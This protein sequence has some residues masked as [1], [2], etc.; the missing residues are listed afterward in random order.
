MKVCM[1]IP[2]NN[3]VKTVYQSKVYTEKRK[4]KWEKLKLQNVVESKD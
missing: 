1:A 2:E 3:A 4:Q